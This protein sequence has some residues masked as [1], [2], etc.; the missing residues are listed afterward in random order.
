MSFIAITYGYNQ[1]SIF[2]TNVNTQPL[3]DNIISICLDEVNLTLSSR[4][5]QLNKEIDS[6]SNEEENYKKNL[7][8]LDMDRMKEEERQK[9]LEKQTDGS[10]KKDQKKNQKFNKEINNRKGSTAKNGT[11]YS[12]NTNL[13]VQLS[14]EIKTT[15]NKLNNCIG[16]REKLIQKKKVCVENV[17]KYK[18]IGK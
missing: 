1:F 5:V 11:Q 7:K 15:E 4:L 17:E 14:E 3:I 18:L 9:D 6:L 13:L 12:E 16:N 2:N 8:R 10:D